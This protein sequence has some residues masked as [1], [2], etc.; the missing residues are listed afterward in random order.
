MQNATFFWK[1]SRKK[2]NQSL[3]NARCNNSLEMAR[4]ETNQSMAKTTCTHSL[5]HAKENPFKLFNK[6][7]WQT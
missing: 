3:D 2:P 1:I 5:G 4:E 7:P 6:T